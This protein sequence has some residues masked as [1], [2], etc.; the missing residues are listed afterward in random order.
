MT[1]LEIADWCTAVGSFFKYVQTKVLMKESAKVKEDV[2]LLSTGLLKVQGSIVKM[3]VEK[4]DQLPT[5]IED[6]IRDATKQAAKDVQSSYQTTAAKQ[7]FADMVKRNPNVLILKPVD[8]EEN[9][10]HRKSNRELTEL[11]SKV[12][13][14]LGPGSNQVKLGGIRSTAN[15][16]AVYEFATKEDRDKAKIALENC[17]PATKYSVSLPRKPQ[18]VNKFDPQDVT[19]EEILGA[20]ADCPG[21][22]AVDCAVVKKMGR[23][24]Q[25]TRPYLLEVSEQ[26][27]LAL[28]TRGYVLVNGFIKCR[29]EENSIQCFACFAFGHIA[30]NCKQHRCGKCA[31]NDHK[32]RDSSSLDV[33]CCK[34][35]E[36]KVDMQN[37]PKHGA[38]QIRL[39]PVAKAVSERR[40]QQM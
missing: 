20:V 16:G 2:I 25:V 17:T 40:F 18:V 38:F 13:E 27:K 31:S 30:A 19:E 1:P 22:E 29:I 4:I 7:T 15:N 10:G 39:C 8:G 34:C 5:K 37:V 33:K 14:A 21:V 35:V 24:D 9:N 11:G 32:T 36:K 26:N 3:L 6:G 12:K 23:D 28:L